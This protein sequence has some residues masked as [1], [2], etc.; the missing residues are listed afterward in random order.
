MN[1]HL[2]AYLRRIENARR[3]GNDTEHTHRPA[4]QALLEALD[5][6]I[7]V[8]NEPKRIQCGAP[9]LVI[10]RQK[11]SLVL[12]YLEAKDVGVSLDEAAKS[13]QVKK[14]YLPALPNFVLTDY[15]EFRWF[16]DGQLRDKAVLGEARPNGTVVAD[17]GAQD[18]AEQILKEF[19]K[20]G[21][22]RLPLTARRGGVSPCGKSAGRLRS[23]AFRLQ[24]CA[25]W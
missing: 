15:L 17:P 9:D 14:R 12:G 22:P 11:D 10:T 19:L 25:I 3:L 2:A 13:E 5:G 7:T 6:S 20:L 16:V 21:F 1:E 18:H 8:T 4:L 24:G 23:A